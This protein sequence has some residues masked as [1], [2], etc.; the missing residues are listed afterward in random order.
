MPPTDGSSSVP[1]SCIRH[2]SAGHP[3]KS[4][5]QRLAYALPAP[6][7]AW[8]ISR[9]IYLDPHDDRQLIARLDLSGA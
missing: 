3:S 1:S 6:E 7:T 8:H 4:V 9:S 5:E 2:V